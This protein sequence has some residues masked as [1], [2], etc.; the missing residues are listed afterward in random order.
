M[1]HNCPISG[2]E[3]VLVDIRRGSRIFRAGK[4][5]SIES[6]PGTLCCDSDPI[7]PKTCIQLEF[8]IYLLLDN[9]LNSDH[10]ESHVPGWLN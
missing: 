7:H 5:K 1:D 10:V 6:L 4:P 9:V 3:V 8:T 2:S